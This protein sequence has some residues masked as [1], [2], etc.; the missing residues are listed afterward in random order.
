M[1]AL[2]LSGG[3]SGGTMERKSLVVC[4]LSLFVGACQAEIPADQAA[5]A[6]SGLSAGFTQVPG[7]L[8]QIS[9]A[10]DGTVV[11]VNAANAI[12]RYNGGGSWAQL[13][14]ALMQVSVGSALQIWGVNSAN[15]IF[16]Y[17]GGRWSQIPGAL[18]NVSVNAL[19]QVWGVNSADQIFRYNPNGSW[20]NIAGLLTQISVGNDGTV[21][22]V[23]SADQI[24]RYNG[25]GGWTQLP[26][27]LTEVSVVSASVIYGVNAARQLFVF[28]GSSWTNVPPSGI[29]SFAYVAAASNDHLWA[30]DPSDQIFTGTAT[31]SSYIA[32]N[33]TCSPA[34]NGF[35]VN[36]TTDGNAWGFDN[37]GGGGLFKRVTESGGIVTLSGS[38]GYLYVSAGMF[39]GA[40]SGSAQVNNTGWVSCVPQ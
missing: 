6:T 31:S 36:T 32:T 38:G 11:G 3:R 29:S 9:V 17:S 10:S 19:G 1:E 22:G 20:T 35:Y 21:V 14:G 8:H 24:F 13:P 28:N 33:Y 27:A 39:Y 37:Y 30:L 16:R 26:G 7:R 2:A 18:K 12:F 23:N 34:P 4:A 40:T 5:T 25:S 15:Q